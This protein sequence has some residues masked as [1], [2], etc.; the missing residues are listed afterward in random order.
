MI[1]CIAAGMVAAGLF[2]WIFSKMITKK[3]EQIQ[4]M[5]GYEK[6]NEFWEIKEQIKK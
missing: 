2:T 5:K 1:V 6:C 4:Y 3:A